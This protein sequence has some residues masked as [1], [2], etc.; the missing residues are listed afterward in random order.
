MDKKEQ[1]S[2]FE[3]LV[4]INTV[5]D[6]EGA[7]AYYLKQLFAKHGIESKIVNQFPGRMN[8]IAEIGNG[9][10]PKLAFAGHE[11]TVHQ[12]NND[13]WQTPPFYATVKDGN[14]YGRGATDMKSGLAAQVIAIIELAES[15]LKL[16]GTLRFIATISEELTQGGA[17]LLSSRGF[18]DDLDSMIV[19]EPT[20]VQTKD[21]NAY[22]NSGGNNTD[23]EN[24]TTAANSDLKNQHFI[25]NAHKGA[26]IYKIEAFGRAAHSSTP[27]LGISAID[28]LFE[29][30]VAE[31]Q[32]FNGF[33]ETDPELGPTIY[34]PDIFVGGKQ[35][36]SIPDY[37]YQE[38]M[39]RTIPQLPNDNI[40]DQLKHLIAQFNQKPGFQLKLTV[41]FSGDPVK[42]GANSTIVNVA[43][44]QAMHDLHEPLD[45][46]LMQ[47]SMG[48]DGSQYKKAN[49]NLELVVLGPGNNTAHQ[50]N[51]WIDLDSYYRFIKLYFDIAVNY[52]K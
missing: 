32:L 39:V 20:G 38:V 46:P 44:K 11:D 50:A 9:A 29:Y 22:F 47:I 21:I 52:L 41:E 13:D 16:N 33:T 37:A 35:V 48:T 23:A 42:S 15:N 18:V 7:V 40:V 49:P 36:N 25:V 5:A 31:H 2:I 3:D 45:L 1:L 6:N 4:N 8:L 12:G 28:K 30:R 17:H 27:K 43:R 19:G 10:H 14:L 51:E 34:T 26:L 24:V